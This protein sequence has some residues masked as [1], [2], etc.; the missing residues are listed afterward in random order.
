MIRNSQHFFNKGKSCLTTPIAFF[1]RMTSW[2]DGMDVVY[3]DFDQVFDT[4]P[5]NIYVDNLGRCGLDE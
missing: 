5:H 2:V 4:L 3:L 1:D